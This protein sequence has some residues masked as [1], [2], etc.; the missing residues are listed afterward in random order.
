MDA[1]RVRRYRDE[2]AENMERRAQSGPQTPAQQHIKALLDEREG[3]IIGL[4]DA[5][6]D[7]LDQGDPR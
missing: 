3:R 7:V 6:L 4:A 1:E 2:A 5:L